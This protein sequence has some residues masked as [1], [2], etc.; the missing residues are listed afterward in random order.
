MNKQIS[1]SLLVV[2]IS[3][4]FIQSCELERM[5]PACPRID[6]L[7]PN[8]A[9]EGTLVT[10]KGE[11]FIP[12]VSGLYSVN[13]GDTTI[14]A[15]SVPDENSL[16]FKVPRGKTGLVSVNLKSPYN[17][18]SNTREFSYYYSGL[19]VELYA[20]TPGTVGCNSMTAT[21]N[22]NCF[23]K[24]TGLDLDAEGNLL[25][26]DMTNHV[27]RKFT[28]LGKTTYG[29]FKTQ[30]CQQSFVNIS[31]ASFRDP[32]DVFADP[33]GDIYVA[34]QSNNTIRI[35]R[36]SGSTEV[37]A[38][39]CQVS[40]STDGQ[41]N[42]ATIGVPSNV[43]K[44]GDVFYFI[45]NGNIKAISAGCNI[46]PIRAHGVNEN[47]TGIE[48]SAARTGQ[49]MIYVADKEA[50]NIKAVTMNGSVSNVITPPNSALGDPNALTIDSKGNIFFTDGGTN[51][52][53]VLYKN[54]YLD[55]LAGGGSTTIL[56]LNGPALAAQFN[57]ISGL[58]LDESKRIL[59]IADTKNNVVRKLTFQ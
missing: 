24:P 43:F 4:T 49:D 31:G 20:G 38:G 48:I 36:R 40:M 1:F 51:K 29:Q 39:K 46:S 32:V 28:S 55:V 21:A 8:G 33:G 50:N 14:E 57:G 22:D 15:N 7:V 26:A 19:M 59:Y 17:C 54:G 6:S 16:R 11:N 25:V 52:I 13:I 35:I 42:V 5:D 9:P 12:G 10:I 27:I 3:T 53:Y 18:T 2:A 58:A 37:L 30:G 41:C 56:Y 34:E 47:F 45:D 44:K 23:T